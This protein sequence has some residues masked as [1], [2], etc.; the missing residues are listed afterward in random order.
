[1]FPTALQAL[2]A[3]LGRDGARPLVTWYDLATGERVE[4]SVRTV[5]NWVTK[6]AN[7]VGDERDDLEPGDTASLALPTHWQGAVLALGCWRAG[8]VLAGRG[9]PAD[10]RVVGPD[11]ESDDGA[12][13]LA[14][15]LRPL[16][17]PFAE[18]L[19]VG[20]DDFALVV[21]PQPDLVLVDARADQDEPATRRADG[22]A[23]THGELMAAAAAVAADVG[24]GPGGRLLTDA[25]PASPEEVVVAL[26][27]PLATASS[28]VLVAGGDDDGRERVAAQEGVTA[29]HL[30]G[31]PA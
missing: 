10:L 2:A 6:I 7:Y 9:E 12:G 13:G 27:A 20:W 23:R 21:P 31:V 17:G 29:R 11:V 15:S 5:D 30:G 19:P 18:Q 22:A 1:M 3:A 26:L 28:V 8:L 24:L 25:N 4:L 14:C 16:G